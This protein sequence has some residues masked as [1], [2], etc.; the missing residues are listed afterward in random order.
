MARPH[1]RRPRQ[2]GRRAPGRLQPFNLV[3]RVQYANVYVVP[4]LGHLV[5]VHRLA[6][7]GAER[8]AA[9]P[10]L[11]G[12]ILEYTGVA[13]TEEYI[14]PPTLPAGPAGAA[15]TCALGRAHRGT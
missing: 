9:W 5:Q 8:R 6:R 14:T 11:Q 2:G 10:W 13:V 4:L 3:H 12:P 15:S 1:R 7:C